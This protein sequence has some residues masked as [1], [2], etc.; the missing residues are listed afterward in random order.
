LSWGSRK[1]ANLEKEL[2]FLTEQSGNVIENKG[3]LWITAGE[4]GMFMKTK[5]VSR[6]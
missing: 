4:A 6:L 2:V 5:V 1:P 3:S